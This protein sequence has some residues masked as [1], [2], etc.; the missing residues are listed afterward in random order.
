[1]N[2]NLKPLRAVTLALLAACSQA[3]AQGVQQQ[4]SPYG[5][6]NGFFRPS[7]DVSLTNPRAP[8]QYQTLQSASLVPPAP[9]AAPVAAAPAPVPAA[10]PAVAAAPPAPAQVMRTAEE[11]M[12]RT[13]QQAQRDAVR[14]QAPPAGVGAAWDG[15]TGSQNR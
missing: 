6:D 3:W 5:P 12:D 10:E 1:M 15:T 8:V 14:L 7:P 11:Q 9:V 13:E 4:S 2:A